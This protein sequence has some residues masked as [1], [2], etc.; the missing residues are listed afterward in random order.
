MTT[1]RPT[2]VARE[3][4]HT[5]RKFN[6]ERL[7]IRTPGGATL[8]REIIRHP[9]AVVVVPVLPDGRIVL[10]RVQ[11]HALER[12]NVECCAGTIEHGEAPDR[13]AAREL[14]EETGYEAA[15]LIPIGSFWT[16]PGMTDERMHAFLATGLRAVGQK[17]EEDES[18]S[19]FCVASGEALA[20]IERGELA[21]AKSMIAILL[22][23]RRGLLH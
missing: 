18:I 14:I 9:G 4:L 20:M 8:Q 13:C 15:T 5:G 3:V 11:R 23:E 2:V 17:L 21:D 22:A 16:T 10:I 19:V 12:E 7:T 6:F 1:P